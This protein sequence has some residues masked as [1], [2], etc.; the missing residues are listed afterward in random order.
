[1]FILFIGDLEFLLDMDLYHS[2]VTCTQTTVIMALH[3]AVF[4]RMFKKK[5]PLTIKYMCGNLQNQIPNRFARTQV[6]E[7]VPLIKFI[8]SKIQELSGC[9]AINKNEHEDTESL[10]Y[11]DSVSNA[12]SRI[13]RAK[14]GISAKSFPMTRRSEN[15]LLSRKAALSSLHEPS[16]PPVARDSYYSPRVTTAG[17]GGSGDT[18]LMVGSHYQHGRGQHVVRPPL[19]GENIN[20]SG[21]TSSDNPRNGIFIKLLQISNPM[22]RRSHLD[23]DDDEYSYLLQLKRR[24]AKKIEDFYPTHSIPTQDGSD[25]HSQRAQTARNTSSRNGSFPVVRGA[26]RNSPRKTA[27]KRLSAKKRPTALS[28][29]EECFLFVTIRHYAQIK[30][31]CIIYIR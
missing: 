6:L 16:R 12:G 5:N 11:V 7:N 24:M 10:P 29:G 26:S 13:S 22:V 9:A 3:R 18:G 21:E 19:G 25:G 17:Y 15:R 1:M 28:S 4:D 8:I 31:L 14:S 20:I 27:M 30:M 2:T 23:V